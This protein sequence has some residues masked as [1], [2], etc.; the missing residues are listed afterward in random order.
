MGDL[1]NETVDLVVTS[2]PYNLGI[3]YGKLAT[4]WLI[5]N[6]SAA[7]PTIGSVLFYHEKMSARHVLALCLMA[8]SVVLLWK[9]RQEDE[10]NAQRAAALKQ[11]V[12]G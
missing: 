7:V 9:D 3:R 4:S 11:N 1:P 10:H 5:I 6:L 2:P 12:C 8:V